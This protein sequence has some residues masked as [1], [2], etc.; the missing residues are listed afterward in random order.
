MIL[1]EGFKA[2]IITPIL[3]IVVFG[4]IIA[5]NYIPENV[6]GIDENPYITVVMI[7]LLTYALPVVFYWCVRGAEFTPRMRISLFRPQHVLYLFHAS[8]FMLSGVVLVSMLMYNVNPEAF[9]ASAVTEYAAFAMN[10]RFFDTVYIVVAFAVLPAAT[11]EILF[12]GIVVGEYDRYGAP[13][14]CIMSAVMFAMSH[15]SVVRFPVYLFSGLV[16][17]AVLF[18]T[19]SVVASIVVHALNNTVVL[20]CEKYVLHIVDKQNASFV[21]LIIL[22]GGAAVIS[23]MLMC[24]EAQGIYHGYAENNVPSEYAQEAKY[25]LF[26]RIAQAFF[27]PT[28]LILVIMFIAV[29]LSA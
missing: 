1:K 10:E 24:H 16:L 4:L 12:R 13:I 26:A 27:T 15:F 22:T 28:F 23:A 17:A 25:S 8:V 11:E 20:L 14:A 29:T 21:L 5:A 18:T 6:I 19:R 3:L 7:T 9:A 2:G